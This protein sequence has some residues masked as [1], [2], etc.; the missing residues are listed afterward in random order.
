[1]SEAE[2]RKDRAR[3]MAAAHLRNNPPKR[4]PLPTTPLQLTL[5]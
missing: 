5:W 3:K 2:L 4:K 1:M